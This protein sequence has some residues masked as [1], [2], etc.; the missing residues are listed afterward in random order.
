MPTIETTQNVPFSLAPDGTIRI[1]ETR[2]S[3]DSVLHHYR[4]GATAEEIALKFPALR[5]ADVHAC[6]AYYL[7]HQA[8]LDQYLTQQL[9]SA[10]ELQQRISADPAQQR[11]LS[12]MRERIKARSAERRHRAR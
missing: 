7:N 9:Q 12:E 8:E 5:L 4:Q 3:L 10:D 1:G 2:V 11:G 6:L